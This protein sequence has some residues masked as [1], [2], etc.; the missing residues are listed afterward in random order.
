MRIMNVATT[1]RVNLS[2][3]TIDS[4]KIGL[5]FESVMNLSGTV[6]HADPKVLQKENHVSHFRSWMQIDRSM[7]SL[8]F[9]KTTVF[10]Q[11]EILRD[12][13]HRFNVA[14]VDVLFARTLVV[15]P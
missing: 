1:D 2:V 4:A 14:P 15:A 5:A 11:F 7:L 10:V 12:P 3:P 8:A 9:H 6:G 13:I